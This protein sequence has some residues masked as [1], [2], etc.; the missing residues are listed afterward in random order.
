MG[1]VEYYFLAVF[2]TIVWSSLYGLPNYCWRIIKHSQSRIIDR[3]VV[4]A[5]FII[6]ILA[7]YGVIRFW[8]I[9]IGVE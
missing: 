4:I 8:L 1:K 7:A 3:I 9:T 2:F 6:W 5:A